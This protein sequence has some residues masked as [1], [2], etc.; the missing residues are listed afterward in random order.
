MDTA[1][2]KALVINTEVV[3]AAVCQFH[4]AVAR[5]LAGMTNSGRDEEVCTLTWCSEAWGV[6]KSAAPTTHDDLYERS[7]HA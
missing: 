2:D 4:D 5:L 1:V 7:V 3:R 6:P